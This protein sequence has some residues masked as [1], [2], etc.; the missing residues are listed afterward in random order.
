MTITDPGNPDTGSFAVAKLLDGSPLDA[1]T[2]SLGA[3]VHYER[4]SVADPAPTYAATLAAERLRQLGGVVAQITVKC[5]PQ[6]WLQPGD[7]ITVSY[8]GGTAICQVAGWQMNI[9]DM[10]EMTLNLRAWRIRSDATTA[11]AQT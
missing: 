7:V 9:G 2:G 6:P 8:N 11:A 4:L 1:E 3:A 5:V 10:S